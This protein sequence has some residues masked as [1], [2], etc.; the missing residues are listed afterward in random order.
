M[1]GDLN[2]KRGGNLPENLSN[3]SSVCFSFAS[4]QPMREL[5][6]LVSGDRLFRFAGHA[7]DTCDSTCDHPQRHAVQYGMGDGPETVS[8]SNTKPGAV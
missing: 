3:D 2:R 8:D 5:T 4:N 1:A 6:A 7:P